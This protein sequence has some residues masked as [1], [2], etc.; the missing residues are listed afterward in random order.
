MSKMNLPDAESKLNKPDFS[1]FLKIY[2]LAHN[3]VTYGLYY[4]Q[5]IYTNKI[6]KQN[7]EHD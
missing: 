2:N 1:I 6:Y 5:Y 3:L 7:K 4:T